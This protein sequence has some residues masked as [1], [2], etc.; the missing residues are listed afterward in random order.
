MNIEIKVWFQRKFGSVCASQKIPNPTKKPENGYATLDYFIKTTLK[1]NFFFDLFD[2]HL[3]LEMVHSLTSSCANPSANIFL[4]N[5]E[6]E[7]IVNNAG[8]RKYLY[9]A[10]IYVLHT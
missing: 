10:W 8:L 5:F 1:Y 3:A 9:F 2:E 4:V 7:S 6:F